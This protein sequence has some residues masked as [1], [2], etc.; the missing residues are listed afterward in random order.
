MPVLLRLLAWNIASFDEEGWCTE[1]QLVSCGGSGGDNQDGDR[2]F[3]VP[4][5]W[6]YGTNTSS[7]M[8]HD[9]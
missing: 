4:K 9:E 1:A 2:V 5:S 8:K 3:E 6:S 7:G